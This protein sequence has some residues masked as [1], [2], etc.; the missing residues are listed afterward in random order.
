LADP[1]RSTLAS[2]PAC[3]RKQKLN[4]WILIPPQYGVQVGDT[5]RQNKMDNETILR[6]L[7]HLDSLVAQIENQD[8]VSYHD[9]MPLRSEFRDFRARVSRSDSVPPKS[10]EILTSLEL[11]IDDEHLE[12]SPK[13]KLLRMYAMLGGSSPLLLAWRAKKK[14]KIR[15]ELSR[16]RSLI[17]DLYRIVA[18]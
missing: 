6:Y 8:Y 18:Q 13:T 14:E 9:V 17:H 7:K 10:K 5:S 2:P 4:P 12:G 15:P 1:I 3:Y 16:V 11:R